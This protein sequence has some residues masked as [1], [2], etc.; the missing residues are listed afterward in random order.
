MSSSRFPNES[1]E[2]RAS[3]DALLTAEADLR[4]AVER[5]AALRRQLPMGGA[6]KEDYAFTGLDQSGAA[7]PV[8]FSE[9]FAPGKDSLFLY[10]MMFSEAMENPC[11]MCSSFLDALDG[12][13]RH[14]GVRINLA[15]VAKSPIER[16]AAY[17]EKRGWRYLRLLSSAGT[18]YQRD[19]LAESESGGQM[20][21]ANVFVKRDGGVHHFWGSELLYAPS[22]GHP[23]HID[24]MWPLWNVLDVTPDGRGSANPALWV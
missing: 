24:M 17:A 16:I 22:E 7:T 15:V 4:A 9:L 1:D 23:R 8:R 12:N 11:P 21:M 19:Y 13:A 6:L 5:V 20:P 14:I 10:G 18:T 2:Y 3:R